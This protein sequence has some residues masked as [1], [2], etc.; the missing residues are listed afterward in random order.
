[1]R[2]GAYTGYAALCSYW[3]FAV[4]RMSLPDIRRP[5]EIDRAD[6]SFANIGLA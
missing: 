5:A 4:L 2:T 6:C 3:V 1:M